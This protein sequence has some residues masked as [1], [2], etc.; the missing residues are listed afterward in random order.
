[1]NATQWKAK[2]PVRM[3]L[4]AKE[5]SIMWLASKMKCSRF[6]I[7]N[8]LMG[9]GMPTRENLELLAK[10]LAQDPDNLEAR[11][12]EWRNTEHES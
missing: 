4:T 7:Y 1:M 6:T 9:T 8:W 2:N 3:Y 12:I 10:I 5:R 11:M